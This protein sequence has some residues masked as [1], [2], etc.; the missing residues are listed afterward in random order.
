MTK[1]AAMAAIL[2]GGGTYRGLGEALGIDPGAA[3]MRAKR[4]GL[5]SL[6]RRRP[7]NP[8]TARRI[9]VARRMLAEGCRIED[10][11]ERLG[12]SPAAVRMMLRRA[13]A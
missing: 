2:A 12:M 3:R 9:Q 8:E 10:A 5:H 4:A 7:P 1:L 6:H 11:A 13:A